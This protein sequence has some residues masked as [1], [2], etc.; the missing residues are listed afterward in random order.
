MV[1]AI[2]NIN[3]DANILL[4]IIKAEYGLRDKSQ[5]INKMAEEYKEIVFEPKVKSSYLR[6]LKKI[7]QEPPVNIGPLKAFRK[8]YAID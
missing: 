6:K 2:I 3:N 7:Q 8:R 1:K 4:N 5:A